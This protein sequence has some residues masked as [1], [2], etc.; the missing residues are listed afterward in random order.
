MISL[1]GH[2]KSYMPIFGMIMTVLHDTN[3]LLA[4]L[5][6]KDRNHALAARALHAISNQ[7]QIVVAPV[8]VELF[9]LVG[10]YA[11]YIKAVQTI[12]GARHLFK[13]EPLGDVDMERME[14]IMQQ[15][16]SARLDYTDTAI[17]AVAE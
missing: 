9:Y 15:Y 14:A 4:A 1:S 8:L 16:K 11:G 2:V 7:Q 17:M 6:P 5:I 10:K 12:T 3:F 13:I